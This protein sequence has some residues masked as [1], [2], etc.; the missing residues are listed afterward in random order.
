MQDLLKHLNPV[1]RRQ[2]IGSA[3]RSL[4]WGTL[5]ASVV[6]VVLAL[7]SLLGAISIGTGTAAMLIAGGSILGG[8]AALLRPGGLDAAARAVD[9]A[10]HLK[11]RTVSAL[12]FVRQREGQPLAALQIADAT[13]HL[14]DT[15]PRRAVP[16]RVP[17]LLGP[18]LGAVVVALLLTLLPGGD[19]S[20]DASPFAA[21]QPAAREVLEQVEIIEERLD[22]LEEELEDEIETDPE[23]QELM[24]E[25][26]AKLEELKQPNID[27]RQGLAKLSEMQAMLAKQM[28]KFN[29][30]GDLKKIS[31]I[32]KAL[33][34]ATA[35]KKA[36]K[37]M[38]AQDLDK[39]ISE[40]EKFDGKNLNA[41]EARSLAQRLKDARASMAKM[42]G[43]KNAKLSKNAK[44]SKLT[45]EESEGEPSDEIMDAL[46]EL[47]DELGEC[48]GEC[49]GVCD[50]VAKLCKGLKGCKGKCK[51]AKGLGACKGALGACKGGMCQGK[52]NGGPKGQRKQRS[53]SPKLTWGRSS[54]GNYDD[55]RTKIDGK[56]KRERITGKK[57]S[58]PSQK[59]TTSSPEGEEQARREY[60]KRYKQYKKMSDAVLESE[61]IPLGHRQT[62]RRYFEMI[63]P[64]KEDK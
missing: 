7:L 47:I 9:D 39:A 21:D 1:Q 22:A 48:E 20:G 25:L 6:V 33:K 44:M 13:R 14:A 57:G 61:A 19:G 59:E 60:Q 24:K 27:V 49:E 45:G 23:L 2:Q 28:A 10:Y 16:A 41:K 51:A 62:I 29:V 35:F 46:D 5:A 30:D 52:K 42:A 43:A 37:A 38:E 15:D 8:I 36:G 12:E 32:G 40:L 55:E 64:A 53:D 34:E 31:K 3:V 63:R 11:D 17:R 26:E 58:G 4:L 54:S 56:R 18:T 50:A